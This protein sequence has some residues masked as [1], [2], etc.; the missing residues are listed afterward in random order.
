MLSLQVEADGSWAPSGDLNK[1][2][3][4]NTWKASYHN[5]RSVLFLEKWIKE[6]RQ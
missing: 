3:K 1:D 6:G 5:S 4:G 2:T